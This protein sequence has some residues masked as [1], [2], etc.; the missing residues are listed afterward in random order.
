M[1]A[2][3]LVT[4]VG[5]KAGA[6]LTRFAPIKYIQLVGGLIFILFGIIFLINAFYDAPH[7]CDERAIRKA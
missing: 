1:M 2:F 5:V 7:L 3:V 6:A 4:G